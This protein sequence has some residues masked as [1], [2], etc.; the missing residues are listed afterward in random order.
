M[1]RNSSISNTSGYRFPS[2][3]SPGT[4]F[5]QFAGHTVG[6]S[7]HATHRAFPVSVVSILC[8]PRHRGEI[9]DFSSGYCMVYLLVTSKSC[10]IVFPIPLRGNIQELSSTN[11]LFYTFI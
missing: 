10:L 5:M 7:P 8:V 11:R 1:Q 2:S 3:S 9:G 6:H 4:S